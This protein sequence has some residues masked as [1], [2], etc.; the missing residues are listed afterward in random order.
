M[1]DINSLIHF[2]QRESEIDLTEAIAKARTEW[3][4][5]S[6]QTHLKCGEN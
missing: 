3:L 4:K 2:C 6:G 5:N 1:S